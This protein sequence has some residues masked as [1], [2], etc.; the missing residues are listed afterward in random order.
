M[1]VDPWAKE[2]QMRGCYSGF[3]DL[4]GYILFLKLGDTE[5]FT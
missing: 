4:F 3:K 1:A 2:N 5:I